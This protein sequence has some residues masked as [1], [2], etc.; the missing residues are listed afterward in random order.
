MAKRYNVTISTDYG[1]L[2]IN[3]HDR[4]VGWQLSER[5]C[6][7]AD[8]IELFRHMIRTMKQAAPERQMIMLDIGANIGIHSVALS[9]EIG[10][11]GRIYAFEAQRLVFYM[12]AGNVALNSLENVHC[13]H[14]AVGAEVGMID[15]PQF[16][17]SK[18]LIQGSV[19]FGPQQNEPIGQ[20]RRK[21]LDLQDQVECVTI[22]S[23]AL[24]RVDLM[25]IDVEG[26][27]IQVLQGAEN[28]IS[29]Y[30]PLIFV[31][32]HKTDR[33]LLQNYLT[34]R[35]YTLYVHTVNYLCIHKSSP[36]RV[37]SAPVSDQSS[38]SIS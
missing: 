21:D 16:D 6:Y 35:G 9:A 31:E 5:G 3:K 25:K 33:G 17:F 8:E 13:L 26:M 10:A 34:E 11:T 32:F 38:S 19:E 7:D 4:G 20:E 28:T 24:P 37:K 15:I 12:L 36:I 27:E 22:D 18:P 14:K 30:Y 2:I 23:L 29:K 1:T